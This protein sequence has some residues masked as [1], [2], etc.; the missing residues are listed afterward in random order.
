MGHADRVGER[1]ERYSTSRLLLVQEL[2][3]GEAAAHGISSRPELGSRRAA[4]ESG[5]RPP[6]R[7]HWRIA[8]SG[9]LSY[10]KKAHDEDGIIAKEARKSSICRDQVH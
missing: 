3:G 7:Q 6:S 9:E 1:E 2:D 8:R 4:P 10:Q 5:R